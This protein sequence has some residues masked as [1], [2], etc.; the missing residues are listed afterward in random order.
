MAESKGQSETL[1]NESEITLG[2]LNAV[3][4]NS[5][6]TQRSVASDLGIALGLT[7]AYLKRCIR[8][9]FIKV[10]QIPSNRYAYYLT[11]QGF[12]EKTRL[13]ADYL[14]YSFT[15]FR[16]ARQQCTEALD[17]CERKGWRKIALA[18]ASDLAEITTLCAGETSVQI[19]GIIDAGSNHSNFAGLPVVARHQN[20]E[21]FDAVILTNVSNPQTCFDHLTAIWPSDRIITPKL[22]GVSEKNHVLSREPS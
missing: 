22:L 18:G 9:G 17:E 14:A 16:R 7:N 8:K 12:A 10:Q 2:L 5:S 20:L 15:F 4:D 3:H 11:P 19:V 1:D 6:I 13:T 21:H